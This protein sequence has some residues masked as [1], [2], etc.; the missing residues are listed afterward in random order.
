MREESLNSSSEI[1]KLKFSLDDLEF[2]FKRQ[3]NTLE[4]TESLYN[5]SRVSLVQKLFFP[6]PVFLREGSNIEK[7]IIKYKRKIRWPVLA[8]VWKGRERK[9]CRTYKSKQLNGRILVM[10]H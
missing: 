2:K 3:R 8:Y 9:M 4:D 7:I 1:S 10:W 6:S 5:E